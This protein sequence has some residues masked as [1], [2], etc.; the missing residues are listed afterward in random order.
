GRDNPL[1]GEV[2]QEFVRVA[3]ENGWMFSSKEQL[4]P[5]WHGFENGD[6]MY[7]LA[8]NFIT[9]NSWVDNKYR[10]YCDATNEIDEDGGV[11]PLKLTAVELNREGFTR[12]DSEGRDGWPDWQPSATGFGKAPININTAPKPV[13]VCL[14]AHLEAKAR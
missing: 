8:K 11:N 3:E 5:I 12:S 4:R 10:D 1:P 9:A 6:R 14:F 13:L 2:V 7:E